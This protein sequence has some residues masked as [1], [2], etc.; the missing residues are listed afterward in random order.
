MSEQKFNAL[1]LAASFKDTVKLAKDA[2]DQALVI[3]PMRPGVCHPLRSDRVQKALRSHAK[4]KGTRLNKHR[5]EEVLDELD[6]IAFEEG[7]VISPHYR[8]APVVGGYLYNLGA[9]RFL[10][11]TA[12]GGIS[13]TSEV[14]DGVYFTETS[15]MLS[16]PTPESKLD[17]KA[18]LSWFNCSNAEKLLLLAWLTYTVA[19]PKAAK[20]P[21]PILTIRAPA[22]SGKT[23]LCSKLI[24]QLVDPSSVASQTMPKC[25]KDVAISAQLNHVLIY[26]NL[27][28]IRRE[29]SDELCQV[30][31]GG[32]VVSRMLYT[33]GEEFSLELRC[34]L[35]LNG[36]HS[37]VTES[38]L[39]SRCVN[40][41]LEPISADHRKSEAT[42][43]TELDEALPSLIYTVHALAAK[44]MSVK[45]SVEVNYKSRMADFSS[46]LAGLE[47]VLKRPQGQLQA[48]YKANVE[49]SK[50][51]GVMDD[52]LFMALTAFSRRFSKSSP[53]HDTPH[54]LFEALSS[55]T[56][57]SLG[58]DMPRNASAMSRHIATMTDALKSN[59]VHTRRDRD[60]YR[61]YEVWF[62]PRG[63][64]NAADAVGAASLP[65]A[66][67]V[68][69]PPSE[70]SE[71]DIEDLLA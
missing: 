30:A 33:N 7:E 49:Q 20:L 4:S 10:H 50:V 38:D 17:V 68:S 29:L 45:D 61:Y 26:D 54:A 23:F 31:T 18:L 8:V 40:I 42:L 52:S 22:G 43:S 39:V 19:H 15:S 27:R 62:E 14:P 63:T 55:Q 25:I 9:G 3:F 37:F 67:P 60:E 13:V 71:A 16:A 36:I 47:A 57:V 2:A 44:I 64:E 34:A 56:S 41:N 11:V 58:S 48:L 32:S 6:A 65:A 69:P 5:I 21:Y 46:W 35:V 51:V 59:G 28:F 1:V 12:V 53:W 24:R 66:Q 70:T